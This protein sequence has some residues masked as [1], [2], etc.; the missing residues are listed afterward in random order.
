MR[1]TI[2]V[3]SRAIRL[4]R[5]D[6][7][8]IIALESYDVPAGSDPLQALEQAPLPTPLG[9][10]RLVLSHGDM[11]LRSMVQP[12]CPVERLGKIVRFE[13][14]SAGDTEPVVATWHLVAGMGSGDMRLLTMVTKRKLLTELRSILKGQGGRLEALVHPAIGVYQSYRALNLG[15]QGAGM[16]VDIGGTHLHLVLIQ[17]GELLFLRTLTPGMEDLVKQVAEMRNLSMADAAQLVAKLGKGAPGDMHEAIKRQVGAIAGVL[18]A[19]IKFAKAQLRI[20]AFDP[21]IIWIAGAGAQV[22]GFS[23][24]LSER[25]GAPVLPINPFSG[26]RLEVPR[27]RL[28]RLAALPSPW[29]V[30]I[31]VARAATVELDACQ[32]DRELRALFWRTQGALRVA[33]AAVALLMVLALVRQEFSLRA[34]LTVLRMLGGYGGA[35]GDT[36]LVGVA[37]K[38]RA[39]LDKVNS[40][41]AATTARMTWI[42]GERRPGR[43][44]VEMLSAIAEQGNPMTCPVY[45][46]SYKVSRKIGQVEI[47]LEG[48]AQGSGQ[49]ASDLILRRFERGLI[50]R[51]IPITSIKQLP[52]PID[53][54]KQQFHFVITVNDVPAEVS[55]QAGKSGGMALTLSLPTGIDAEGAAFVAATRVH[56]SGEQTVAVHVVPAVQATE[57]DLKGKDKDKPQE[58]EVPFK[59]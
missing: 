23:E 7:G 30:A 5:E 13:L 32:E 57:K 14:S 39:E 31:G 43:V 52:K 22:H 33:A 44:A 49:A 55:T 20:D 15:E 9:R 56:G 50:K 59:D 38:A 34:T 29:S 10:V 8:R 58:I 41:K 4:C 18:A 1:T 37:E 46:Q 36:G 11:L 48:F 2:E 28:D 42:D 45:L 51:Y 3:T 47:E 35:E 26:A 54:T 6:K 24:A 27:E 12:P 19:N 53:P 17:D 16:I 21:K 25:M 40:E